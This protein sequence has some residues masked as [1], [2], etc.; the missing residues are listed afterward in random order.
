MAD[1]TTRLPIIAIIS[2]EGKE[3]KT[4]L[5]ELLRGILASYTLEDL[6]AAGVFV[7]KLGYIED[8]VVDDDV[9][10]LIGS[11]VGSHFSGCEFLRHF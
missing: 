10:A 3:W 9:E 2:C 11:F 7:D 6:C 5:P 8:I 1:S 4:Y